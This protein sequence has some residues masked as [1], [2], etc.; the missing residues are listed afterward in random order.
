MASL[1]G[2]WE[3]YA[4]WDEY[5]Y[6]M[7]E[8][9]RREEE[10][11]ARGREK[12]LLREQLGEW[13]TPEYERF[14]GYLRSDESTVALLVSGSRRCPWARDKWIDV[15]EVGR[16]WRDVSHARG[17]QRYWAHDEDEDIDEDNSIE[18]IQWAVVELFPRRTK[19]SH[20]P[21]MGMVNLFNAWR[22]GAKDIGEARRRG[23]RGERWLVRLELVDGTRGQCEER[24]L[25]PYWSERDGMWADALGN[26]SGSHP[27]E[28]HVIEGP[29]PVW[30]YEVVSAEKIV[31]KRHGGRGRSRGR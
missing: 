31:E 19:P 8:Q 29:D 3:L 25:Q 26:L 11:R 9:E 16:A 28:V 22:A 21:G 24:V 30:R 18:E 5:V 4:N 14:E 2:D 13:L 27:R 17:V 1:D 12:R 23:Y 10:S 15:I 7:E 6:L 20:V